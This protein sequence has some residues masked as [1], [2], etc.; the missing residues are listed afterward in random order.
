MLENATQHSFFVCCYRDDDVKPGDDFSSWLQ[1]VDSSDIEKVE[2][3]NL[4]LAGVN[5]MVSECLKTFPRITL[6]LATQLYTKTR[7]NPLFLRQFIDSLLHQGLVFLSL[8]P[9]RWAWDLDK[10]SSIEMPVNVV[11]LLIAEMQTLSSDLKQG[12]RVASCLG[13]RVKEEAIEI[14]SSGLGF[15]LAAALGELVKKGFLARNNGGAEVT[16][17]HDKVQQSAYGTMATAE[18][19]ALHR[20]LGLILCEQEPDSEY[21]LFAAVTQANLGGVDTTLDSHKRVTIAT[22]NYRVGELAKEQ[23]AFDTALGFFQNSILW[24]CCEDKWTAHY[25]LTLAAHVSA[26]ETACLLN[27]LGEVKKYTDELVANAKTYEERV[28]SK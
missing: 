19:Q 10:I 1:S 2:I 23:S 27:N 20:R 9:T 4:S 15:D 26:V 22:L 25:D 28:P 14:I 8:N 3:E 5:E 24:I 7:G 16:F 6:P 17:T 12:L 21:L 11:A 13:S 18:Q